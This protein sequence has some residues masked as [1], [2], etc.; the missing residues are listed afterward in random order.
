MIWA[1]P[2][3]PPLAA[4]TLAAVTRPSRWVGWACAILGLAP[5]GA[6]VLLGARVLDGSAITLGDA[7]VL[8]ADALSA[9]LALCVT[10]VAALASWLGPRLGPDTTQA[11]PGPR[12][13]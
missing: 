4:A 2:P 11:A 1:F 10:F 9:V 6:A 12:L 7:E 5:L 3:F 13:Q 8:R